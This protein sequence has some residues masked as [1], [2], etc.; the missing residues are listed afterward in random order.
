[1]PGGAVP[2]RLS[3]LGRTS[4]RGTERYRVGSEIQTNLGL[5]Y[6]VTRSLE[7]LLSGDFRIRAK[8]DV[9]DTDAEPGH[10]GGTW[11]YVSPGIRVQPVGKTAFYGVV[12]LPVYQRVNGI[13]LVSD[14]NLYLGVSRAA[15]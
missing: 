11:A 10:T 5:S 1:V 9:G 14:Y 4:G 13:N 7:L 12:Q 8:D 6:P 15:F 2:V 3:V